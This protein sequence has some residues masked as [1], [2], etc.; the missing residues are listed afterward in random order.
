MVVAAGGD[1]APPA[2]SVA[3]H[4]PSHIASAVV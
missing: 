2:R 4:G 1:P 3:G